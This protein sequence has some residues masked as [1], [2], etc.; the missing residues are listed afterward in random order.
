MAETR[1]ER[2]LRFVNKYRRDTGHRQWS[3]R[4]GDAGLPFSALTDDALEVIREDMLRDFWWHKRND[5]RN[6]ALCAARAPNPSDIFKP[7]F[8]SMFKGGIL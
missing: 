2:L 5:C 3:L 7:I 1:R 4:L 6:R 8:D